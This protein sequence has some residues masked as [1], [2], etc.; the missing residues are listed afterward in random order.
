MAA[1]CNR[2]VVTTAIAA[3]VDAASKAASEPGVAFVVPESMYLKDATKEADFASFPLIPVTVNKETQAVTESS[4]RLTEEIIKE[5]TGALG[6]ICYVVQTG[7][8]DKGLAEFTEFYPYPLYKDAE[9]NFYK[10]LGS[11]K[12]SIPFNPFKLVG[13][14]F[15]LIGISGRLKEKK[16]EGNLVGEGIKQGGVIIFDKLGKPKFAYYEKT[17]KE[18]PVD[19]ILAALQAVKNEQKQ[20]NGQ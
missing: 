7:V 18:L 20:L 12:L 16:I 10:A 3:S 4:S 9:L 14:I 15:S 17:G 19:D 1:T 11:R 13:G 2:K 8:D 5:H 6:S